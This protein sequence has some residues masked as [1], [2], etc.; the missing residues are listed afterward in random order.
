MCATSGSTTFTVVAAGTGPF[1]YQWQYNNSGTWANVVNGTPAGAIYTT[2]ATAALGVAGIT[3]AGSYQYHCYITN[4]GG[5]N[6]IN[7]N[8]A[9]LTLNALPVP[10]LTSSDANNIF[11]LGTSVTFTAGGGGVGA[12]YDFMVQ[13]A[14][15]Q[16]GTTTTYTTTS[17]ANAQV[18]TV[19]VTNASLCSATSAGIAN[20]VN[21]PPNI[22]ISSP[23]ACSTD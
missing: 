13:G 4:C 8:V 22:Y 23:A 12:R 3:S 20:F 7:S 19:V 18:V 16:T 6:F 11:C 9:T 10:T 21:Q 15:V 5:G 2:S 1:A 14:I 17:L